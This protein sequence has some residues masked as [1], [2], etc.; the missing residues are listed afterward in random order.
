MGTDPSSRRMNH[1]Q[2][3]VLVTNGQN[4]RYGLLG[5]VLHRNPL[6]LDTTALFS[7]GTIAGF[8]RKG[9]RVPA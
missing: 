6:S 9:Q 3:F 5:R 2:D 4:P 7:N 8:Q 1:D